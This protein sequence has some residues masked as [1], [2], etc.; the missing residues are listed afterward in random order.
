MHTLAVTEITHNVW[1]VLFAKYYPPIQRLTEVQD[2]HN[3]IYY[4]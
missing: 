4:L 1:K 3:I 2:F